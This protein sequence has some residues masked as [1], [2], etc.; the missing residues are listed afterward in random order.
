MSAPVPAAKQ[1]E[2]GAP[3]WRKRW[4]SARLENRADVSPALCPPAGGGHETATRGGGGG[5]ACAPPLRRSLRAKGGSASIERTRL[6]HHPSANEVS[7]RELFHGLGGSRM[8]SWRAEVEQVEH[9]RQR[10]NVVGRR[11][12]P[13]RRPPP[14]WCS[15][16]LSACLFGGF[17]GSPQR[18]FLRSMNFKKNRQH[19]RLSCGRILLP[20]PVSE[21]RARQ[22]RK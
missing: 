2:V 15:A 20:S 21:Q 22:P 11:T 13:V 7:C 10:G 19:D 8:A 16:G 3:S 14:P 17:I 6:P 18:P 1:L 12:G 5:R 4:A 9:G